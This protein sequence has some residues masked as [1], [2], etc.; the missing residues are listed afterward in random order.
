GRTVITIPDRLPGSLETLDVRHRNA[1]ASVARQDEALR[2]GSGGGSGGGAGGLTLDLNVSAPQQI[3]IM[4]RGLD[5]ELGGS[6]RLTG[7]LASP[8]AV[9]RFTMRRGRL[10]LL[11]RRLEFTSGSV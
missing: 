1:P 4:G 5:V 2:A 7:P 6:L 10:A 8:Q 9:G 3:F 11:G